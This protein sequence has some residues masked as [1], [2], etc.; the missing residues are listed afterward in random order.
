MS[1]S[2]MYFRRLKTHTEK[3]SYDTTSEKLKI[4]DDKHFR[5]FPCHQTLPQLNLGGSML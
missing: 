4:A 1:S 5:S 3:F 2:G